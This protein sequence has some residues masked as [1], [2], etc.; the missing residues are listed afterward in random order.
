MR[1]LVIAAA[2]ATAMLLPIGTA[3]AVADR[4][5]DF[6]REL[7]GFGI[8]GQRDFN[9]WLVKI[10]CKRL[11]T[12]VDADAA[13]SAV[14]L[15]RNLARTTSTEQVW[16]FL[17]AGIPRYCPEHIGALTAMSGDVK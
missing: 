9:A 10:T 14:F 2:A 16:Q 11:T 13:A 7:H 3:T 15:S 1:R 12:G 4:D 8:Y 6:A 5:T 17:G